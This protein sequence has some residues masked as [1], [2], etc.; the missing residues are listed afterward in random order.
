MA[1]KV[2]KSRKELLHDPDEFMVLSGRLLNFLRSY[3]Q[4]ALYALLGIFLILAT[5]AVMRFVSNNN[6]DKASR[7]WS[8]IKTNYQSVLQNQ[9]SAK[10]DAGTA[11]AEAALAAVE[12]DFTQL[13]DK[14]GDKQ[15]GKLARLN[16]AQLCLAAGKAD[17]A[18]PHF[19]TSLAAL[20]EDPAWREITLSGLAHALVQT[21][22]HAQ[23]AARFE[24]L[25]A[26]EGSVLKA[27]ALFQLGWL[28]GQIQESEKA[29]QAYERLL[30][31]YPDS[32]YAEL[33]RDQ[34]G[35]LKM[36]S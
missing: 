18:L 21:G 1:S 16:Y 11:G 17:L 14:Y 6:E 27:D 10:T 19:K 3:Q 32:R 23:A 29:R 26:S 20:G 22:E 15:S 33:V 25:L 36:G 7:I 2:K 28:Y 31:D 5:V 9:T 13:I 30:A 35:Q 12:A 8:E 34:I 4:Q 24:D